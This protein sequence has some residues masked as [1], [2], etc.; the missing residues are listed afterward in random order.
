MT[1]KKFQLILKFNEFLGM[2]KA[3]RDKWISAQND[4]NSVNLEMVES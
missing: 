2:S 3:V 1:P 4:L